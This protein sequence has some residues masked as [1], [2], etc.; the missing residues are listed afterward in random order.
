MS[1]KKIS[2]EIS[3][4]L[5]DGQLNRALP[6]NRQPVEHQAP[7][8]ISAR[9]I[10]TPNTGDQAQKYAE[11][12][13]ALAPKTRPPAETEELAEVRRQVREYLERKKLPGRGHRR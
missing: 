3:R 13:N 7:A 11:R 6:E 2:P 8:R 9:K 1:Y 12:R 10:E 4:P 5:I